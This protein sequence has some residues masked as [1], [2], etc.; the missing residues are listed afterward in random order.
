MLVLT[1]VRV[2]YSLLGLFGPHLPPTARVWQYHL[3]NPV[4]TWVGAHLLHVDSSLIEPIESGDQAFFW[5]L[6]FCWF[7]G[8]VVIAAV[9]SAIDRHR[10]DYV[11]AH[12]WFCVVVRMCLAAQL[13][14]FGFSKVFPLQMSQPL[15]RL[16]EPFGNFGMLDVLWAQVGSSP[17]YEI[18]LGCAEVTAGLLLVIPSTAVLG[19]LLAMVALAQ[20]LVLDLTFQIPLKIWAFQLFLMSLV[21]LAP[22]AVRLTRFFVSDRGAA[23]TRVRL[24][25]SRRALSVT[26]AAQLFLGAWLAGS[27]VHQAWTLWDTIG[28]LGPKPPLYGMWNVVEFSTDGRDQPPLTTDKERWN[29]FVVDTTHAYQAGNFSSQRMDGTII[30]YTGQLDAPSHTITL[31]SLDDAK[32]SAHFTYRQATPNR[33]T[34]NGVLGGHPTSMR[35][36]KVDAESFPIKH[37]GFKWVQNGPYQP[38]LTER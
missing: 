10:T 11:K 21:L 32:W 38:R 23:L 1:E 25:R 30:D 26:L 3:V 20:V 31:T 27:Q 6:A 18:L 29:R 15:T 7:L 4:V 33:L 34:L 19:A 22:H 17:P 36:E 2:V 12:A 13:F 24:F 9:W 37:N 5:V 14:S 35:L 8:A 16:V 28:Q